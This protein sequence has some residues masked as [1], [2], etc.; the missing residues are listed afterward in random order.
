[1]KATQDG[2]AVRDR[3]EGSAPLGNPRHEAFAVAIVSGKTQAAAYRETFPRAAGWKQTT[4]YA[5]GCELAARPDVAARIRHLQKEAA[6]RAVLTAR[7]LQETLSRQVRAAEGRGDWRGVVAAGKLLA[8]VMG[9]CAPVREEVTARVGGAPIGSADGEAA[10]RVAAFLL[11]AETS[12]ME[13]A[14]E[15]REA[16]GAMHSPRKDSPEIEAWRQEAL[17]KLAGVERGNA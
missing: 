6:S 14:R 13:G 11:L 2:A 12:G 9:Y 15:A 5:R 8:D 1:M 16:W 17:G 3:E 7:E 10:G 4:L